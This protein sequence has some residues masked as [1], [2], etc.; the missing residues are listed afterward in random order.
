MY[1]TCWKI[2]GAGV[3]DVVSCPLNFIVGVTDSFFFF[4][5]LVPTFCHA[6]VPLG[7]AR[8]DQ[9]NGLGTLLQR[10]ECMDWYIDGCG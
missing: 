9:Q 5:F 6:L 1:A 3:V 7:A 10:T 8:A 2:T 4:F